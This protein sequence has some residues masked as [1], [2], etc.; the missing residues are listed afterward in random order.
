M[1]YTKNFKQK[2]QIKVGATLLEENNVV[3]YGPTGESVKECN[4][5][6]SAV[7]ASKVQINRWKHDNQ[8]A[9]PGA[10]IIDRQNAEKND[11]YYGNVP[12]Y[13]ELNEDI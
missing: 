3:K 6:S 2:K 13:D 1:H 7:D 10:P 12:G 9:A 5:V 8:I 11:K 4:W